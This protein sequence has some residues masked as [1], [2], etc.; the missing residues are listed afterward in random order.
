M[1]NYF[2]KLNKV[3]RNT[4]QRCFPSFTEQL[5]QLHFSSVPAF[6]NTL[7]TETS[8]SPTIFSI[9]ILCISPSKTNRET[10]Q[11]HWILHSGRHP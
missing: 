6:R 9:L 10:L 4:N 8:A 1:Y 7:L 2:Q 3:L 5:F 11:S